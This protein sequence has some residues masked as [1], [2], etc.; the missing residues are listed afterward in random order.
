MPAQPKSSAIFA[1]LRCGKAPHLFRAAALLAAVGD[2]VQ[3]DFLVERA[4]VV[5][6]DDGV[7]VVA[8][9]RL[10]LGDVVVEAAVAGE[11][12]DR[13]VGQRALHAE[14]AGK[15]PAERTG[16]AVDS[17]AS[18]TLSSIMRA[19]QMPACP[20]SD[21]TTPFGGSTS[22]IAL[23]MR[24]GRIGTASELRM[25]RILGAPLRDESAARA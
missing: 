15:P 4:V 8:R 6:D 12:H 14:R 10:E 2:V 19:V 18:A 11:A 1:K 20:V 22:E 24:S 9:R 25:R 21:T 3:L 16:G 5:D 23:Q 13:P 17:A 7:D